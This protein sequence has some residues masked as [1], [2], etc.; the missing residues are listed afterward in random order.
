MLNEPVI[1]INGKTLTSAESAVV[2]IAIESFSTSLQ[3]NDSLGDDEHGRTMVKLY[4]SNVALIR[5][6]I[7]RG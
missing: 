1:V 7:Y 3:D 5:N 6:K 2:R 4:R